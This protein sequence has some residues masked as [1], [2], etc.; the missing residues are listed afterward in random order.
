MDPDPERKQC[1]WFWVLQSTVSRSNLLLQCN[2]KTV[3]PRF[4]RKHA[5]I[6]S[7]CWKPGQISRFVRVICHPRP[8]G[9]VK[10]N[11]EPLPH[12]ECLTINVAD[13]T[14]ALL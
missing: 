4:K 2:I 10:G 5:G 8:S 7:M 9:V 13:L 3:G 12:R 14:Q 1:G 11:P 6:L